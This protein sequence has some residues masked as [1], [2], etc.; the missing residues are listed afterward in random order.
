MNIE[1]SNELIAEFMEVRKVIPKDAEQKDTFPRY[2]PFAYAW[3]NPDQLKYH[4]AWD[5]LMPVI[6]KISTIKGWTISDTMEWL[7]DVFRGGAGIS[8][9][10][11]MYKVSVDFINWYKKDLAESK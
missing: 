7:V 3:Y 1:E 2:L 10:E 8:N 9:I 5:W 6:E 11:E 4:I